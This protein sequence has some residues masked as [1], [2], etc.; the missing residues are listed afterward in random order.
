MA[1]IIQIINADRNLSLFSRG[2]KIVELEDK[3]NGSGPFTI[4]GPVNLALNSLISLTYS[5]L[6]EP[7]NHLKLHELLSGYIITGKKMFNDFRHQQKLEAL[8]GQ[9]VLVTITNAETFINGAK[10]LVRNRQ[11]ANGVVHLLDK[12]YIGRT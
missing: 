6:L 12:T 1:N 9:E 2:L 3:L 5:Q 10:I 8:N 4:L 11:G 7:E